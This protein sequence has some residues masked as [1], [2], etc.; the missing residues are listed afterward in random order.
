MKIDWTRFTLG[1]IRRRDVIAIVLSTWTVVFLIIVVPWIL[2][3]TWTVDQ[4]PVVSPVVAGSHWGTGNADRRQV[5]VTL[6]FD[7]SDGKK[8]PVHCQIDNY[9]IGNSFA[10]IAGMQ[11]AV[12]PESCWRF[13]IL[14]LW[15]PRTLS[16]WL[17][18]YL[19]TTGVILIFLLVW[20]KPLRSTQTNLS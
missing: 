12:S 16:E 15:V 2:L 10:P 19:Q 3:L 1:R 13:W 14:P 18:F 8:P 6:Y 9:R 20:G 11:I 7:R 17:L 4:L 5:V